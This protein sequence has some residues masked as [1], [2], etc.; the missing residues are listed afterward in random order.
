MAGINFDNGYGASIIDDGYGKEQRLAEIAV[1]HGTEICYATP[2]TNDV[3]GWLT[4]DKV[5]ATLDAIAS[6]TPDV[7]CEHQ[8]PTCGYVT[9][10]GLR[11]VTGICGERA[12][13]KVRNLLGGFAH[14]CDDHP[15]AARVCCG[16]AE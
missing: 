13:V 7:D 6:L 14:R 9:G 10:N 3:L 5:R 15:L 12:T 4:G 11:M 16:S 8:P 2:I 1:T